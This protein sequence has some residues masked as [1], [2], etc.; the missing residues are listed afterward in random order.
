MG[1]NGGAGAVL[2]VWFVISSLALIA[3]LAVVAVTLVKLQT[4]LEEITERVDP[5]LTKTDTLLN[6][7]EEKLRVVG[8]RAETLLTTGEEIAVT[9]QER[10]EKTTGTVQR[11]VNAPI[12]QA[13]A[14]MTGLSRAWAT[15]GALSEKKRERLCR[16]KRRRWIMIKNTR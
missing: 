14:V 3:L 10:V 1:L 6:V 2:G 4:K 8:D 15:F 13:N 7:A 11:T 9:V 16:Q 12:I 5:L